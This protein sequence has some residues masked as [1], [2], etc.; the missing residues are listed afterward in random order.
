[1]EIGASTEGYDSVALRCG[2]EN[3]IIELVTTQDFSGVIY[4]QGSFHSKKSPCFLD[5]KHGRNFT[6]N[7]PLD[8]CDTI[9]NGEKFSNVLIIQHDDELVT[10][11]DAAFALECD[12]TK[13]RELTVSADLPGTTERPM[14][15]SIALIDADPGRD[16]AKKAAYI[17]SQTEEVVFKPDTI[18]KKKDEL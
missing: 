10:P 11:G 15:S 7:I 12:F 1:M 2:V 14:K 6:L 4:T 18:R 5:P 16:R 3:M 9:K 8:K 17:E 13:P